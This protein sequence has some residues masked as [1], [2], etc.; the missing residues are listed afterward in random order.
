MYMPHVIY[1]YGMAQKL[2]KYLHKTKSH[3]CMCVCVRVKNVYNIIVQVLNFVQKFADLLSDYEIACE[4][5][6]SNC[7]LIAHK[8]V[9]CSTM[10]SLYSDIIY[11]VS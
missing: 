1:M 7:V 6:H 2:Y 5:E 4:H 3:E 10:Y 8:K 11:S 9:Q